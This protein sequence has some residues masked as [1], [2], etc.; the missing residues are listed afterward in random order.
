[1]DEFDAGVVA[2]FRANRGRVG[3]ALAGTP[4]VLLHHVGARSGT[5]RITPLAYLS[6]DDGRFVIVASNGGSPTHPAWYH[7]LLAHPRATIE[8][9]TRVVSVVAEE[10]EG[11]VRDALWPWVVSRSPGVAGF[12]A[13]TARR[14]PVL[15]LTPDAC[16]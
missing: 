8:V 2:E 12:Q 7:N 1:M 3:G 10:A 11:T 15:V 13:R 14:I 5:E 9:G 16:P 6:R 4:I